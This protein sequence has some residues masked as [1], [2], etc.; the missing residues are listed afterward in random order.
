M[1]P[2][3]SV[4]AE[5]RRSQR[6]PL[7]VPLFVRSLDPLPSFYGRLQ[8]I[9]VSGHGCV[10]YAPRP[11]KRGL[12]LR[13]DI[14]SSNLTTTARV[15]HSVPT[16][17]RVPRWTVALEL[18]KPGNFWKLQPPPQDWPESSKQL[19]STHNGP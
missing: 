14:L 10:L 16:G 13:L 6:I 11:L 2:T 7:S 5:R 12:E 3:P 17:S 9:Q 15:V 1:T 8:T 4:A 18:A 19:D